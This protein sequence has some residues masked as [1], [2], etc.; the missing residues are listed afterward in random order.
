M[1]VK[2]NTE[3]S[4]GSIDYKYFINTVCID[5][6][7]YTNKLLAKRQNDYWKRTINIKIDW[8]ISRFNII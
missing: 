7:S 2:S 5:G 8:T 1:S 4:Y 6:D 3:L